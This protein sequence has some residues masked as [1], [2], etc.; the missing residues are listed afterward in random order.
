MS[1]DGANLDE[2]VLD[3][4]GEGLPDRRI[5]ASM[6]RILRV[7]SPQPWAH[8]CHIRSS[9]IAPSAGRCRNFPEA[10]STKTP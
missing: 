9:N 10:L 5:G 7:T 6:A 1:V 4:T 8:D 3:R 2:Q